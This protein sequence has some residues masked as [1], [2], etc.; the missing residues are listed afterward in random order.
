MARNLLEMQD[1][2]LKVAVSGEGGVKRSALAGTFV[3]LHATDHLKV[4]AIDD[5]PDV[6]SASALGLPAELGASSYNR[7]GPQANRGVEGCQGSGIC[8]DFQVRLQGTMKAQRIR[9]R[10]A[11][12]GIR[13]F[14]MMLS[15]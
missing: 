15:R 7:R 6:N 2:A 4:L 1:V 11:N 8:P 10:S 9:K 13:H 12:L 3:R 14:A 5:D